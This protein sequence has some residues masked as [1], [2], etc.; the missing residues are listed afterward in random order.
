MPTI[1]EPA[2]KT[3]DDAKEPGVM[4][5]LTGLAELPGI[6]S[7][8]ELKAAAKQQADNGCDPVDAG[9]VELGLFLSED[10]YEQLKAYAR[11]LPINRPKIKRR[12]K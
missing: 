11:K 12:R 8:D 5:R 6:L 2:Y 4:N 7:L 3:H 1:P 10:E 9:T